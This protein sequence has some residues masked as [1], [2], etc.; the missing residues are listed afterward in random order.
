VLAN[1]PELWAKPSI[2]NEP[3]GPRG[4][5]MNPETR[6]AQDAAVEA[7]AGRELTPEPGGLNGRAA[8]AHHDADA[9]FEAGDIDGA[10]GADMHA[11]ALT[12]AAL[13]EPDSGN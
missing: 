12:D 3:L 7:A 1:S 11:S 5:P 2:Y 10:I 4:A 13:A 8:R 6:R 9:A